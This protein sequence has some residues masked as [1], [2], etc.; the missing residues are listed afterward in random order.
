MD[1]LNV[2]DL[3]AMLAM[4]G[5]IAHHGGGLNPKTWDEVN[6]RG[7]KNAYDIADAM[8]KEKEKRDG[9]VPRYKN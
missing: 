2:R 3:F 4:N 6:E 8:I 7:A 9:T 5:L 1:D